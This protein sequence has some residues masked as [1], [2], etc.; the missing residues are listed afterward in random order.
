MADLVFPYTP[1]AFSYITIKT[2]W[3][4]PKNVAPDLFTSQNNPCLDLRQLRPASAHYSSVELNITGIQVVPRVF[5]SLILF[6]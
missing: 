5:F 1:M 6:I 2:L 3:D 4:Q